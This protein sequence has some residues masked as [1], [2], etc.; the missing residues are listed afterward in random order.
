MV[1]YHAW[2]PIVV[3]ACDLISFAWSAP[4][5]DL[6][7]LVDLS[8]VGLRKQL[9]GYGIPLPPQGYWNKV[10]AAREV[11]ALPQ[12]EP[13]KPGQSGRVTVDERFKHVIS[14]SGHMS[15][16]SPFT[17]EAVP[18]DLGELLE[19]ELEAIGSI[20]VPK[21]LGHAPPGLHEILRKE[22]KRRVRYAKSG[23][24][25]D[26]PI[27]ESPVAQRKL[28]ILSALFSALIKRGHTASAYE[29][30]RELTIQIRIGDTPIGVEIDA[31]SGKRYQR[32]KT[33]WD[34]LPANTK[35]TLRVDPRFEGR[36]Y[37][38]WEDDRDGLIEA[39]M[40][41]IA[42]SIIVAGEA[43]FRSRLKEIEDAHA[44]VEAAAEKE[45]RKKE[46]ALNDQ[47][48]NDLKTSAEL[49][50]Q[51]MDIRHLVSEFA[52]AKALGAHD[53]DPL[54][55]TSWER[56]ALHEAD[57]LDPIH[58]GQFKSHFNEPTLSE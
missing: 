12:P 4:L 46:Q 32:E 8:D 42:A 34:D 31:S 48:V 7:A 35:L 43:R 39:K 24:S 5:R 50:R 47:R 15:S 30:D 38:S 16:A 37:K 53:I 29:H 36:T 49:L 40:G 17:S 25:F 27:Y 33:R 14:V 26:G 22:E 58:S 1:N 28:R 11:P 55:F 45:R 18:E 19:R 51:A 13:R 41:T 52:R 23:L 57:K 9:V 54:Q 44:L 10:K 2:K 20:N 6:A 21:S 56:W 3:S